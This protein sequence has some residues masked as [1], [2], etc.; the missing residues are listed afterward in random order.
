MVERLLVSVGRDR[1]L[2]HLDVEAGLC[3][4][5]FFCLLKLFVKFFWDG[6]ESCLRCLDGSLTLE[7]ILE[8]GVSVGLGFGLGSRFRSRLAPRP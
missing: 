8:L 4:A 2:D 3:A 5:Y 1:G 6:D 7:L